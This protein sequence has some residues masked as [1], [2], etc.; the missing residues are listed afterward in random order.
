MYFL[1]NSF[2]SLPDVDEHLLFR[3]LMGSLPKQN[4]C[5]GNTGRIDTLRDYNVEKRRFGS[6]HLF[7]N[8]FYQ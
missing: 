8:R 6:Y 5:V 3:I 1:Q 2:K 7:L 4:V